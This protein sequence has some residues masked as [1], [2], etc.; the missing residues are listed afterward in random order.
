MELVRE[1]PETLTFLVKNTG[2]VYTSRLTRVLRAK[3]DNGYSFYKFFVVSEET[4]SE[5]VYF[6]ADEIRLV[7]H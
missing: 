1:T 4:A 2:I 3:K 5:E 6:S 7:D